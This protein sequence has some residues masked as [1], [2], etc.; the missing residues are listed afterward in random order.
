MRDREHPL[1][2]VL[3]SSVFTLLILA[4]T[5]GV[6][7]HGPRKDYGGAMSKSQIDILASLVHPRGNHAKRNGFVMLEAYMDESGIHDG[8]TLCVVG[9]FYGSQKE[10]GRAEQAWNKVVGHYGLEPAGFHSKEFWNRKSGA[11]AYKG[12]SDAQAEKLLERLVNVIQRHRIFPF[13]HGVVVEHWNQVP[14]GWRQ[15]LTGAAWSNGKLVGTGSPN[16]SYY[17]PFQ[18]CVED[19]IRLAAAKDRV[20]FYAGL[21]NTFWGYLR[22]LYLNELMRDETTKASLG[23]LS[24]PLSKD[25]PG[26]QMADLLVYQIYRLNK[27]RLQG[28]KSEIDSLLLDRLTKNARQPMMVLGMEELKIMAGEAI[29]R[30]PEIATALGDNWLNVL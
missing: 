30:R 25:T 20:H 8:A 13:G 4:G 2:C 27:L 22:D 9:G 10:W 23:G 29:K 21:D 28:R 17:L 3:K 7:R 18:Y 24:F 1:Q 11:S 12:L 15:F 14:V 16:R 19:C 5:F 26:I 6:V